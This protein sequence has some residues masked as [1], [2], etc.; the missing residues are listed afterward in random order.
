MLGSLDDRQI[1]PV[2][3]RGLNR[4]IEPDPVDLA[5]EARDDFPANRLKDPQLFEDP[6][7]GRDSRPDAS[8][9]LGDLVVGREALAGR[10]AVEALQEGSEDVQTLGLQYPPCCRGPRVR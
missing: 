3:V 7:F 5:R 6:Q 2:A 1:K 9:S 8:S 10:V 4:D